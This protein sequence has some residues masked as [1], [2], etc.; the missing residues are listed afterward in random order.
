MRG[1]KREPPFKE[2]YLFA[3]LL[4]NIFFVWNPVS[5]CHRVKWKS[6]FKKRLTFLPP[7]DGTAHPK[8]PQVIFCLHVWWSLLLC[9]ICY[10]WYHFH[11]Y[12]MSP[13]SMFILYTFATEVLFSTIS[14]VG[15]QICIHLGFTLFWRNTLAR[16]CDE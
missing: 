12:F 6:P 15:S 8:L 4:I 7:V 2:G 14:D 13:F 3:H 5:D 11:Y 10:F 1:D 16:C 9:S